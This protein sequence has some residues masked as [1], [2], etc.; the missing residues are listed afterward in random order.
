MKNTARKKKLKELEPVV[1]LTL[2][3]VIRA[4]LREFVIA[5]C[6]AAIGAVLER[7]RTQLVGPRYA[8]L[9]GRAA[10]RSGSAPGELVLGGR[11]VQ[12][13]RP[14]ART[15]AGREVE[16]PSWLAFAA[17]DPLHERAVEQMLVGVSTRSYARSL[18]PVPD[19]LV[20]RGTSRS[21]VSRRFVAATE[22]QM[23]EWLGRDL[24]AIDLVVLMI[25]GV[26]VGDDHVML[27]AL[28]F[29]AQGNKHVL[30]V[31][32]GATENAASCTAL[33]T[34]MRDRGL[35]T[36]RAVLAVID[37]A[38]ALAKAV[39][40]VFGARALVQRCQQ[41]KSRN[42]TDQ[43]P[44]ELKPS[45]RQALR[46]A[47]ACGDATRAK[48]MIAN[49]VRRLRDEHPGASSS[50]EE[51]LDETLTV[52][53]LGLPSRL[54]RQLSTTNAIE[55]VIGSMR[56]ISA[57]VKRWR[58]GR[59]ILRWTVAAL[60]DAATRFRRVT[61]AREGMTPLVRALKEHENALATV[62]P[63]KKAA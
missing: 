54:E 33:L 37:G 13:R 27:V 36:D 60:A 32:E 1:Q 62:A 24:S 23:A 28:G 34:E 46:D 12:V 10:H 6:T 30:G 44:E 5:A 49:L 25:D 52:K 2:A 18:E 7:E 63:R 53:R 48:R 57:R 42:V 19:E 8:H 50:L 17:E 41:H 47:Y 31:R 43:V 38:K 61:G 4:D 21:A 11:R 3:D 39:R 26:Y 51:G 56:R 35:R 20:T 29:D 40:D 16:L 58:G 22:K 14:R 55:N 15:L 45:V 59:M 9:P